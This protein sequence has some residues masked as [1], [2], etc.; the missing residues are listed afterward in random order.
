MCELGP[1]LPNLLY[2][3]FILSQYSS[4]CVLTLQTCLFPKS[5]TASNLNLHYTA[6]Y[7]NLS[8]ESKEAREC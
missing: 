6:F 4:Y 7:Q 2:K 5:V 1:Y 8:K 3:N